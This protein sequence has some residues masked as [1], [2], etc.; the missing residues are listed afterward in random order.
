[1]AVIEF[2]LPNVPKSISQMGDHFQVELMFAKLK[3]KILS[4][5]ECSP[6]CMIWDRISQAKFS[7]H[8]PTHTSNNNQSI[9][10][11]P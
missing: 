4:Q 1:M 10:K 2:N 7:M 6:I 9:T 11:A 5:C 3:N 8:A